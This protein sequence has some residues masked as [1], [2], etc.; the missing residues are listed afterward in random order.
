[1]NTPTD[2]NGENWR[3]KP[4]ELRYIEYDLLF[5][6]DA[7]GIKREVGMILPLGQALPSAPEEQGLI[8]ISETGQNEIAN[9]AATESGFIIDSINDER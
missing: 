7:V 6:P 4:D 1:M 2:N 3:F 8:I 5:V 9:L